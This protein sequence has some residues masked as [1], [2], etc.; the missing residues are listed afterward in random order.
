MYLGRSQYTLCTR[1]IVCHEL[2]KYVQQ[3]IHDTDQT[4]GTSGIG[5]SLR[6][7]A[8]ADPLTQTL[9]CSS[10]LLDEEL[11]E[12]SCRMSPSD[13]AAGRTIRAVIKCDYFFRGVAKLRGLA[14][15]KD[16]HQL[17]LG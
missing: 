2:N 5:L 12:E 1:F 14:K 9:R 16:L 8:A 7:E 10:S 4:F 3:P 15:A 11:R 17:I 6:I 13:G